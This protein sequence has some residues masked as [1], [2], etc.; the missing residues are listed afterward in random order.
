MENSNKKTVNLRRIFA[1]VID[2]YL[3][4][5]FAGIPVLLLYSI[6]S[7][8]TTIPSSLKEMSMNYAIISGILAIFFVFIYYVIV[9]TFSHRGQT[10]GK[11]LLGIKVVAMD[12]SDVRLTTMIKREILGAMIIEGA[13]VC[14][15]SY[16]RQLIQLATNDK[17]YS[18]LGTI[19]SVITIIS[20]VMIYT[21]KEKR[22]IHDFI[23]GTKVI[24]LT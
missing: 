21:T 22:M 8:N 4:S 12:G 14:S 13:M 19:A 9:P 10:L 24:E 17:I 18:T 11:K 20:V 7:G 16:F 2:W 23:G 6:D 3:S 5:V 15:G 1:Y